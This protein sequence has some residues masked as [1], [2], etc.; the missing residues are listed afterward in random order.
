MHP[1]WSHNSRVPRCYYLLIS[2]MTDWLCLHASLPNMHDTRKSNPSAKHKLALLPCSHRFNII[3][4]KL[5]ARPSTSTTCYLKPSNQLLQKGD[6]SIIQI[7]DHCRCMQK[8]QDFKTTATAKK[9]DSVLLPSIDYNGCLLCLS[10]P[11]YFPVIFLIQS[12]A[13]PIQHRKHSTIVYKILS[14]F[15]MDNSD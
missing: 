2:S 7:P 1:C 4:C 13:S 14:S 11:I 9:T 15:S 8:E 5:R 10:S 6:S 3:S 12:V